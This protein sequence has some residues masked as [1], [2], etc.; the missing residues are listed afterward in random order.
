MRI[1]TLARSILPLGAALALAACGGAEEE[2]VEYEVGAEDLSGGELITRD[3]EEKGVPVD[4]PETEMTMA[5]DE[6]IA[7]AEVEGDEVDGDGVTDPID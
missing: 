3:P 5:S 6:E 7:E 4:I 2:D 1:T